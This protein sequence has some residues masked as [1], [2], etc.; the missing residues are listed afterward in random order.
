MRA[1]YDARFYDGEDYGSRERY[2]LEKATWR[3]DPSYLYAT[4]LK[5]FRDVIVLQGSMQDLSHV[6]FPHSDE[7][8]ELLHVTW[9]RYRR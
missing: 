3:V 1:Q 2:D 9:M 5:G 8:L 6:I 7:Y 4:K